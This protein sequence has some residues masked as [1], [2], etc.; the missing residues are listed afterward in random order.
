MTAERPSRKEAIATGAKWYYGKEC[1]KH[2]SCKRFTKGSKC[3]ECTAEQGHKHYKN[4]KEAHLERVSSN[5]HKLIAQGIGSLEWKLRDSAGNDIDS[6]ELLDLLK[7]P[8]PT[9][10]T[11][12]FFHTLEMHKLISG[13][14]YI[15]AISVGRTPDELH[16]L[17]PDRVEVI[18]AAGVHPAPYLYRYTH[19]EAGQEFL[20]NDDGTCE[21]LHLYFPNPLDD[22]C[23]MRKPLLIRAVV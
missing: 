11:T 19:R 7:R 13:N 4:N 20:V 12:S 18:E 5:H 23:I 2:N 22:M 16:L 14:A 21:V 10:G 17:R 8:N 1:P 15:R 9:Q 6:H 3:V